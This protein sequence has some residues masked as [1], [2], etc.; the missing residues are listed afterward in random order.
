MS[1]RSG[2]SRWENLKR[3]FIDVGRYR[4]IIHRFDMEPWRKQFCPICGEGFKSAPQTY[5]NSYAIHNDCWE[6]PHYDVWV[7]KVFDE[8][9]PIE[10]GQPERPR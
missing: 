4:F 1:K 5:M 6:S 3:W 2:M 8:L 10:S 7:N 9:Y